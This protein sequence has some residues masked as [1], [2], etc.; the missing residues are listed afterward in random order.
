MY[1]MGV[2]DVLN[3]T[4]G[5]ALDCGLFAGGVFK[6][7]C[8]CASFPSLCPPADYVATQALMNPE[9]YAP[10]Q[11]PPTVQPPAD[12]SIVAG[13]LPADPNAVVS[14]VLAQQNAAWKAQNMGT[15]ND[16]AYNLDQI[17]AAQPTAGFPT[18]LFVVAGV[19][20]IAIAAIGSGGPRRY[21]R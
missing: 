9:T 14:G 16:T 7:A 18:W 2:G 3:P 17:A 21:G 5:T 20:I 12:P 1:R 10:V 11:Q 19:G 13:A 6:G 4:A 8:W 15:M